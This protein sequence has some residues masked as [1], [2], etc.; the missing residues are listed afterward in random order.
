MYNSNGMKLTPYILVALAFVGLADTLFLSYFAYLNLVPGCAIGG[1]EQVLTSV[2]SKFFGVPLAYLGLVYYAYML[3]LAL[4][5]AADDNSRVLARAALLYTTVGV[6][7]SVYFE[8]YIQA[9]VIG[10]LCMYCAISA[11]ITLGLLLTSVY[12][13]RR[14]I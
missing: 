11:A 14:G 4:L 3:A 12:H 7:F 8:F 13:L 5:L 2:Y 10:A 1:C 9:M 6:L